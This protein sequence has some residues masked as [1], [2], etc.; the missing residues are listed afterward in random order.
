MKGF[1]RGPIHH[2]E[3]KQRK[4]KL[5][6]QISNHLALFVSNKRDRRLINAFAAGDEARAR[7]INTTQN[8]LIAFSSFEHP[9]S[10]A[11]TDYADDDDEQFTHNYIM[12]NLF[13]RKKHHVA[14]GW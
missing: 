14:F 1:D 7:C 5:R 4:K 13:I 9:M 10:A 2:K 11:D 6:R 12:K 3:I 8:P